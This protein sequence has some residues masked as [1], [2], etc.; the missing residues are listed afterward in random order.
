MTTELKGVPINIS[1]KEYIFTPLSPETYLEIS[2]Y[3][4]TPAAGPVEYTLQIIK[5]GCAI[6]HAALSHNYP[7]ITL[8]EVA[9]ILHFGEGQ[10]LIDSINNYREVQGDPLKEAFKYATTIMENILTISFPRMTKQ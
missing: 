4:S 10:A 7:E 6:V 3:F 5:G 1:G 9:N 2:S 8:E